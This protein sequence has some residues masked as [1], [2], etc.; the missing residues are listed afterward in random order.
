MPDTDKDLHFPKGGI[1][2]VSAFSTQP[3][4]PVVPD[5]NIYARTTPIGINVRGY[6]KDQQRIRGGSRSGLSKQNPDQV[7]DAIWVVQGISTFAVIGANPFSQELLNLEAYYN[8]DGFLLNGQ[9]PDT[10]GHSRNLQ[11]DIP[12]PITFGTGIIGLALTSGGGFVKPLPGITDN[13]MSA[14]AWFFSTSG[15]GGGAGVGWGRGAEV[16]N[17]FRLSYR[18]DG[19][20]GEITVRD[21]SGTD[22]ITTGFTLAFGSWHYAVMTY[23]GSTLLLYVDGTLVGG[24]GITLDPGWSALTFGINT[25]GSDFTS[26]IDEVAVWSHPISASSV[27][28]LYNSGAGANP[29]ASMELTQSGRV[30]YLVAVS[31]GVVKTM[32]PGDT[33]WTATTNNSGETPPLNYT[34][35]VYSAPCIQKLFFVDGINYVF[36]EP[37]TS[38]IELWSTS[39][40]AGLLPTDA[41]SNNGRLI[42]LWRGRIVISGLL[43]DPQNWFMSRVSDPFDWDYAPLSPSSADPVAG[44]NSPLG[45]IGDVVTALI[46]YSDDILIVGG[47]STIYMFRGDPAAGGQIDR[48]SDAIGMAWATGWCK[49]PLGNLYFISNRCGVYTMIPGQLPVRISQSIEPLLAKLDMGR[50]IFQ[51]QWDDRYQGFHL[52]ITWVDEPKDTLHFFYESRTNAWWQDK[53]ANKLHNPLCSCVFDGNSP[54]DRALL[55]GCWDGYVRVVDPDANTDDG[56]PIASEVWIGPILTPDFDEIVL[57]ELQGVLGEA[58]GDVEYAVFAG[59]TAEAALESE[60]IE[61]ATLKAGRNLTDSARIADHALYIRLTSTNQWAMEAIRARVTSSGRV[62]RRGY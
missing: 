47:D 34:G 18:G 35:L 12:P 45:L 42:C 58:S 37:T 57:K 16:G 25:V 55:I 6:E 51:L 44:N 56:T 9:I 26:P 62:R 28:A 1:N 59:A 10:S 33:G 40:T 48:V 52:F 31:Q 11:P 4:V 61:I 36:F 41:N 30:V 38:S 5:S 23:D 54:D 2:V 32:F 27:T 13:A 53:F 50:N 17:A 20:N 14:Q 49:D 3:N 60:A 29:I 15:T 21:R 19:S 24:D 7:N 39:V 22:L 8:L 46:P 43:D